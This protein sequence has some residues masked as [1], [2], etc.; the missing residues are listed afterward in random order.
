MSSSASGRGSSG[1]DR[2]E[3]CICDFLISIIM[4]LSWPELLANI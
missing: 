3:Q 4:L 1:R 2:Q